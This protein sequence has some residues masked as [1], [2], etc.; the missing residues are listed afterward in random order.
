MRL[1][2]WVKCPQCGKEYE[3]VLKRE[4]GDNRCIQD[5]FPTARPWEREQL[6]SGICSDE[7]WDK[8]L[9]KPEGE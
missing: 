8:F 6:V 7:C 9:G 2:P 1:I 5:I 4:I 3:P